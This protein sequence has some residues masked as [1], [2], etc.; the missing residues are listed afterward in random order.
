MNNNTTSNCVFITKEQ[1]FNSLYIKDETI[2]DNLYNSTIID[3]QNLVKKIRDLKLK[4][5]QKSIESR[6]LLIYL[7]LL[8][9]KTPVF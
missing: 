7:H 4:Q 1:W 8:T 5:E 6:T 3:Y 9:F 2:M